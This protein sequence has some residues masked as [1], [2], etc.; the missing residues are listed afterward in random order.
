MRDVAMGARAGGGALGSITLGIIALRAVALRTVA[1]GAAG[2]CW[3]DAATSRSLVARGRAAREI[4]TSSV[5][6][7][8][9]NP[10]GLAMKVEAILERD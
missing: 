4:S 7:L 9:G 10:Q 3:L 2:G 6:I 5:G 8:V 1:W